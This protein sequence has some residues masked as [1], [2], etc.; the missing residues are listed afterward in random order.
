MPIR[1]S[2]KNLILLK[3]DQLIVFLIF[4]TVFCKIFYNVEFLTYT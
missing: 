4:D 1:K 2:K 3:C